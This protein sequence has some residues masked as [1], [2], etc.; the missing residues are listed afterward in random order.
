MH[1][2]AAQ[3]EKR[4]MTPAD[5]KAAD[6]IFRPTPARVYAPGPPAR[7]SRTGRTRAPHV[8]CILLCRSGGNLFLLV[9]RCGRATRAWRRPTRKPTTGR[10]QLGVRAHALGGS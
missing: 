6:K 3:M 9:A 5:H 1:T 10:P 7:S 8:R 4:T 2:I